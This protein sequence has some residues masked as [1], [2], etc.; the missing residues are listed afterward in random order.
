MGREVRRVPL[1]FDWPLNQPWEGFLRPPRLRGKRCPDCTHGWTP[2]AEWLIRLSHRI[3]MLSDDIQSQRQGRPLH[4]W[5]A[6]DPYPPSRHGQVQRLS[7]DIVP[8]LDGLA[9]PASIGG[10]SGYHI[11]GALKTAAGVGD[12]WGVC[13]T[14][15]GH[16]E[17][18]KYPGQRAEAE[19]WEPTPPP[20]GEGWQYW[21]TVSEGSPISPV[22]ATA[23]E[24]SHWL[25]TDYAWGADHGPLTKE[26]A[27]NMVLVGW[28]PSA[29]V[30]STGVHPGDTV[31]HAG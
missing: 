13:P 11:F 6:Q 8:L 28:A 30:D 29:V 17:V 7:A 4:P 25:Q 2:A 15:Q 24:L 20:E 26:Q 31:A 3:G 18:E 19:A 21:E 27:D 1:D 14:C 23:R 22:F 5:L 9:G 10:H 16:G 12:D